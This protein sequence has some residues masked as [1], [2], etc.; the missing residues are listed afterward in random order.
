MG[1]VSAS[2]LLGSLVD[3]DVLDNEVASVKT[4]GIGVRL[5]VFEEGE[6]E[7][8]G[9]DGPAGLGNTELLSCI[10]QEKSVSIDIFCQNA[11]FRCSLLVLDPSSL[12]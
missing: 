5:S 3:L 12:P 11:D 10:A 2:S 9:L 4:L 1:T 7:F 6:E 8:C